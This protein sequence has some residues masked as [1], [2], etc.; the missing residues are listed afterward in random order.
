M[1]YS[2]GFRA[3]S[4]QD[5]T[6]QF[7]VYLQDN[8]AREGMY[9]DRDLRPQARPARIAPQMI[10]KVDA[11]LA[12]I[13]W[14]RQDVIHFLGRYLTEPK[15]H[16]FFAPPPEP[17]SLAAFGRRAAALGISLDLRT[18]MLYS[19]SCF[20][21]NGEMLQADAS[22]ARTLREL[23]DRRRLHPIGG[24]QRELVQRLHVWYASGYLQIGP[25]SAQEQQ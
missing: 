9:A 13:R 4:W 6:E 10:A 24:L 1:T 15:P 23:A 7:L 19:G 2:I 12:R 20:F 8:T 3:P 16:V 5:L 25:A 18:Q 17:L 22:T 14:S 11:T 21:I